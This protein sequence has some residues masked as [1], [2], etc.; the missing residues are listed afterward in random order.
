M[1]NTQRDSIKRN[2]NSNDR[3]GYCALRGVRSRP[4]YLIT[5]QESVENPKSKFLQADSVLTAA[6]C[7]TEETIKKQRQNI[8]GTFR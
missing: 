5:Y 1:A 3:I 2:S 7:F 6:A 8:R 4:F